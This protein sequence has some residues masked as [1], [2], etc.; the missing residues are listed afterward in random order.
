MKYKLKSIFTLIMLLALSLNINA[1]QHE[2]QKRITADDPKARN[3]KTQNNLFVGSTKDLLKAIKED[4]IKTI[5]A[6]PDGTT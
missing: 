2:K 3:I 1:D 5:D 6:E 4:D